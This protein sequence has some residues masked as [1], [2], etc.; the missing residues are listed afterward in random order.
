MNI[1]EATNG[2]ETWLAKA[3]SSPLDPADLDYKHQRMADPVD[4]FPF[5]RG[6]YYRWVGRWAEAAGPLARA[7]RVLAVGDLHVENFGTWRDADGRLC[8]GINDFDE[9]DDLPYT[10]D[11]VRLAASV[12]FGKKSGAMEIKQGA[13]CEAI[14]C[15]YRD[16][17]KASGRPFVLEEH[18]TH[19]RAIAMSVERDPAAFWAKMTKL[20]GD[21]PVTLPADAQAAIAEV[22][23]A[24]GLTLQY[25][26]RPRAGVGSLGRLRYV[27]LTNW[28]G[29]WVCREIKSTAPPATAWAAGSGNPAR[30]RMVEVVSRAVRA[31]DPFYRPGPVWV[32]R[33]L[34]PRATRIELANLA[35]AEIGRVLNAMGAEVGNV[36]LGTPGAAPAILADLATRPAGWL[37]E[38]AR[39]L[40]DLIEKDW[41]A[42]RTARTAAVQNEAKPK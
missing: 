30:S 1:V 29:G 26:V 21:P 6:T 5:F 37:E 17:L 40:A 31:P 24:T 28:A 33:R 35:S 7:P 20:L 4:P 13:A 12:R 18:H 34:G 27:A 8:W 23:P 38:A 25:R 3:I 2:Y 10:I 22:L 11:L 41:T 39:T 36:H 19:L 42:W 14:L 16:C 32:A 15:G 9:A